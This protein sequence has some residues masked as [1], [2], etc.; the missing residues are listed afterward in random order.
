MPSISRSTRIPQIIASISIALDYGGDRA[1]LVASIQ[2][3]AGS[4]VVQPSPLTDSTTGLVDAGNWKVTDSWKIP[5]TATSGVYIADLV[6]QDGTPGRNTIAFVVTDNSRPSDILFQ[7]SDQTWEAYNSWGVGSLYDGGAHRQSATTARWL[8][9]L[10]RMRPRRPAPGT[11]STER[12]FLRYIGLSKT[13]MTLATNRAWIRHRME[14]FFSV[15]RLLFLSVTTST[16]PQ[17]SAPT[18]WLPEMRG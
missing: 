18:L 12:S 6:R 4:A 13:D 2:H 9:Q 8:L 14:A 1:T 16:G 10:D 11:L 5:S 17:V 3:S 15:T 7:T